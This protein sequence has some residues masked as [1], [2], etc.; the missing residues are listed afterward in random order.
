M[1]VGLLGVEGNECYWVVVYFR[2]VADMWRA[3]SM[4]N[5]RPVSWGNNLDRL[6]LVASLL[7]AVEE[8]GLLG[9]V[10]VGLLVLAEEVG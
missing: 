8:L 10:G 3:L 5:E 6:L 7:R 4:N 9:E 2:P 1:V